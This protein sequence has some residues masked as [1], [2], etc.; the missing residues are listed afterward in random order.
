MLGSV[1][2]HRKLWQHKHSITQVI[3]M[4]CWLSLTLSAAVDNSPLKQI[5]K[6]L[7]LAL[8]ARDQLPPH[9]S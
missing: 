3:V 7:F 5:L 2:Q 9:A 4:Q 6:R 8:E 1:L